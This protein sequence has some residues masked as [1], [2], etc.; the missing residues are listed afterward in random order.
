MRTL[1]LTTL[2]LS[3]H[4]YFLNAQNS[5]DYSEYLKTVLSIEELIIKENHQEAM[6]RMEEISSSY[7][8]VFLK[9]YK[10]ATQLAVH[11]R[12]FEKAFEYLKLG[13]SNGWTLKEIK[14]ETF[15][16]PLTF[17]GEW[18]GI[19]TEYN[20]LRSEYR[21]RIKLDLREAVQSMYKKDQ[22]FALKYLFKIG[23]KAKEGFGNRKGVPHT[24]QQIAK[25]NS[26]LESKG[27][28]GEKLI[29][30]SQWMLTIYSVSKEF[31]VT[32]TLYP[33]LRPKLLQAIS[34]GEMSPYDFAIIEDW[35]IAIKSDCQDTGYGYL[36]PPTK[37]EISKSNQ[38]RRN[39]TIRSIETR[40]SL[41]D[42]QEKTGMNFYL[43]GQPWLDGKIIS[44]N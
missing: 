31:V 6:D 24:R 9:D 11:L 38:L 32:D 30:E 17:M 23:Q 14:K 34:K 8:F 2:F 35:N 18:N 1:L 26:I 19:K 15:L 39:L 3:L 41:V 27:H 28:P 42:I 25:L 5:T 22:K 37:E 7:E 21:N 44:R 20:S 12:D 13:V 29:G 43:A 16:K 33:S 36:D 4:C 10:I 40:N